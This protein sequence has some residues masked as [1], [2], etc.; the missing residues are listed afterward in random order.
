MS[1]ELLTVKFAADYFLVSS[2]DEGGIVV[3]VKITDSDAREAARAF[4]EAAKDAASQDIAAMDAATSALRAAKSRA[5]LAPEFRRT[6]AD[7]AAVLDQ[8]AGL[9]TR[10]SILADYLRKEFAAIFDDPAP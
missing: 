10:M 9:D 7:A 4:A 5:K 2:D 1:I 3:E 6:V 8:Y